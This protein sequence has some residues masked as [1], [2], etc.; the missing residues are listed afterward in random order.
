MPLH[1]WTEDRGWNGLH[2]AWQIAILDWLQERL[3]PE[4]R[5]YTGSFPALV[6]DIPNGR[7]DVGVRNWQP[8]PRSD[9]RPGGADPAPDVEAVATFELDEGRAIHIDRHGHLVA[10]VEIVSPRYKD[11]PE[12]RE[13]YTGRYFGYLRQGVHLL[14]VDLL[15]RPVG[16]SFADAVEAAV[17]FEQPPLPVPFAVSY[18]VGEPVPEGTILAAWRRPLAVGRPLPTLPLALTVHTSVGID[19]EQTYMR[20]ARRVYL[21]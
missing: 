5:A 13:T 10:A 11:R 1:D 14:L 19:L 8:D 18:R 6:V 12:S 16:F 4:Y 2:M 9:D 20:A 3:P 17:N 21:A 7:P 15:P